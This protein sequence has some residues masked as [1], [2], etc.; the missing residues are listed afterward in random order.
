MSSRSV[1]T[2]WPSVTTGRPPTSTWRGAPGPHRSQA[3]TGSDTAPAQGTPVFPEQ[4]T[5]SSP[6]VRAIAVYHPDMG[7][8]VE[9][10]WRNGSF[11]PLANAS[12][13]AVPSPVADPAGY[14]ATTP[15]G[16]W[17]TPWP[18][19]LRDPAPGRPTPQA[20][21]VDTPSI[22]RATRNPDRPL[23]LF[24]P[25]RDR[26]SPALTVMAVGFP[27]RLPDDAAPPAA[28]TAR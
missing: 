22:A 19:S 15:E 10:D 7:R 13:A 21:L 14:F 28:D 12:I 27:A 6:P 18:E 16:L 3:S 5:E 1:W 26:G 4:P 17:Y 9:F 25:S 23:I 24:G 11:K 2:R 8:M 20:R